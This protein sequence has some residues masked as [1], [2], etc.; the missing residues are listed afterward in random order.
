MSD[1]WKQYSGKRLVKQHSNYIVVKPEDAGEPT[2]IF[3]PVC[4][5][6]MKDS[7]D[8]ISFQE[9]S[10]CKLCELRWAIPNKEKW[11]DGWR[12]DQSLIDAEKSRR[13]PN[14]ADISL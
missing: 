9:N 14:L 8:S 6:P 7:D 13:L 1:G 10:C 4:E 12:P 5:F 11:K 2:A 3:C